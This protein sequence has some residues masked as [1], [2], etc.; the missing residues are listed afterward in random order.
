MVEAGAGAGAGLLSLAARVADVQGTG[1]ERDP[2][3]AAVARANIEA[4]GRPGLHV[5]TQDVVGWRANAAYD[6]AM[7]NPP[8][9]KDAGTQSPDPG[10]RS[11][12]LAGDG[13]LARWAVALARPLVRRG[14]LT[15]VLP[16]GLLAH[17]V[18]ALSEAGCGEAAVLP[19]WPRASCQARLLILRGVRH[20]RGPARML[21]GLILHDAEGGYTEEAEAVLRH[22]KALEF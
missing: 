18:A 15:L 9:H 10:R 6:H 8:W 14:T 19:L 4:N 11:A 13:L 1:I 2:D 7:A 3:I 12:K 16:A 5:L 21:P 22:G 17:G 20:G